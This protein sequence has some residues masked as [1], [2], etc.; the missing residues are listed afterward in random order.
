[1]RP[2]TLLSSPSEDIILYCAMKRPSAGSIWISRIVTMK[3]TRPRKRKRLIATEARNAHSRHTATDSSVT[4]TLTLSAE[5]K[6]GVSTRSKL[7]REPPKGTKVGVA[8]SS[9]AVVSMD[10]LIIQYTGNAQNAASTRARMLHSHTA[11]RNRRRRR[12]I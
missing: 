12:G 5:K 3:L 9:S 4:V 8:D 7:T 6:A 11:G 1:L 10:E 2:S